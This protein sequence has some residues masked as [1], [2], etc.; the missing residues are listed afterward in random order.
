MLI[1]SCDLKNNS[2]RCIEKTATEQPYNSFLDLHV[3]SL[4]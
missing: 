4:V 2:A 1:K 3:T